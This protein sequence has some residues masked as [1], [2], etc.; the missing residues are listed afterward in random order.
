MNALIDSSPLDVLHQARVPVVGRNAR[1]QQV[2]DRV[3]VVLVPA[4]ALARALAVVRVLVV[5][6]PMPGVLDV[7][8]LRILGIVT[9][10][11]SQVYY[12]GRFH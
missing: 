4:N 1:R 7:L 10:D 3:Q 6:A 12:L 9:S 5:A 2:L 8:T 11:Q